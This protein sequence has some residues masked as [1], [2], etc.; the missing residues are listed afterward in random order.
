VPKSDD[1]ATN[2]HEFCNPCDCECHGLNLTLFELIALTR[3]LETQ[4]L[5]YD[6]EELHAVVNKIFKIVRESENK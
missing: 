1:C 4:Y 5:A 3:A 6:D 2:I